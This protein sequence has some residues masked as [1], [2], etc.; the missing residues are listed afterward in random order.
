M[1]WL[2]LVVF[3]GQLYLA[4]F[5]SVESCVQASALLQAEVPEVVVACTL[6]GQEV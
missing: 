2:L 6:A 1:T 5:D 3:A 4:P